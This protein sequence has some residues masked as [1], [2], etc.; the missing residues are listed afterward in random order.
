MLQAKVLMTREEPR[1]EGQTGFTSLSACMFSCR[2]SVG[3]GCNCLVVP[4]RDWDQ[5]RLPTTLW[6]LIG[7]TRLA[8]CLLLRVGNPLCWC[9]EGNSKVEAN[10]FEGSATSTQFKHFHGFAP[11][12]SLCFP[13]AML[14]CSLENWHGIPNGFL[15]KWSL[16]LMEYC[17]TRVSI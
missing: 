12:R 7:F 8:Y 10:E 4:S 5:R 2:K 16:H 9:L 14:Q 3:Q 6:G 13:W 1:N 11:V 15:E 17:W